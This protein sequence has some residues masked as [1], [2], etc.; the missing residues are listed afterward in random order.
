ME[1]WLSRSMKLY[2]ENEVLKLKNKHVAIFGLGGVGSY[3]L[4]AIARSGVGHITIID[5]DSYSISNINRQLY[6]TNNT[7]QRKKV[8]VAKERVKEI[9]SEIEVTTIDK[10]VLEDNI[11]DIDFSSFDY[12]IDAID[13]ISGKLGIISRAKSAG[14][15]VISCMGAGNKTNPTLFKVTDIS[16]TKVCPLSKVMRKLL[17]ERNITGVKVIYSEEEPKISNTKDRTPASNSFIPGIVGLI[18]AGTV[19]NDLIGEEND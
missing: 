10:F 9:S 4:E 14:V 11:L 15:K 3:A 19:I 5:N 1:N 16:N 2:G 6:A 17:K 18:T 13:T 8:E 12:V 7:V